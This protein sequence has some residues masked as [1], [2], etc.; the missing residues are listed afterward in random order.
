MKKE[1]SESRGK[2]SQSNHQKQQGDMTE[3]QARR[4]VAHLFRLTLQMARR[5]KDASVA[6]EAQ[7][8]T[9]QGRHVVATPTVR[10]SIA[11]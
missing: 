5:S 11:A 1:E 7:Q 2:M 8:W 6:R 9:V 3:L 10:L 4:A